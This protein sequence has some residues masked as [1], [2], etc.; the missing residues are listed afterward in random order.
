MKEAQLSLMDQSQPK[1][2]DVFF[3]II[4]S[5][6][7]TNMRMLQTPY[8]ET[9]NIP[10]VYNAPVYINNITIFINVE[11]PGDTR[12]HFL[13]SIAY[14]SICVAK[15]CLVRYLDIRTEDLKHQDNCQARE[16][17]FPRDKGDQQFRAFY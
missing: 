13:L 16:R 7:T 6:L 1:L 4:Q 8:G 3:K 9:Y 12:N 11:F 5:N 14:S 10:R 17:I 15:D 2:T